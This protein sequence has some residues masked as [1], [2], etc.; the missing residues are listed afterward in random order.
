MEFI[1]ITALILVLFGEPFDQL[2]GLDDVRRAEVRQQLL[3]DQTISKNVS[4]SVESRKS[5][6]YRLASSLGVDPCN[7]KPKVNFS[8]NHFE[9]YIGTAD[10]L[11]KK[12]KNVTSSKDTRPSDEKEIKAKGGDCK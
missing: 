7:V 4:T 9:M 6:S 10:E 5:E 8:S 11:Q 1:G 2:I 3:A 12:S